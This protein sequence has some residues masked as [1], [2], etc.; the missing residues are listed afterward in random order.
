MYV[1]VHL[2]GYIVNHTI[3]ETNV[4]PIKPHFYI[5]KL[6]FAGVYLFL[7]HLSRRLTGERVANL[8]VLHFFFPTLYVINIGF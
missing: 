8:L 4:Y 3:R 7:A 1:V 2:G 6:G 5:E